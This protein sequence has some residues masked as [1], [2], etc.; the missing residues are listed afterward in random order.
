MAD[1]HDLEAERAVLG[2]LLH[3]P[4]L[5]E[6]SGVKGSDLDENRGHRAIFAA[7]LTVADRT[8]HPEVPM[9]ASELAQRDQL[10]SI[11]DS[12]GRGAPYL[13]DLFST[14]ALP[15]NLGYYAQRIRVASIRRGILEHAVRL[16]QVAE[17]ANDLDTVLDM[18]ADTMAQLSEI[19]DAPLEELEVPIHGLSRVDE[20]VHEPTAPYAWIIPGVLEHQDRVM[21]VAGEGIGKSVLARQIGLMVAAGRHPFAPKA[22]IPAKRTLL[23]DLENPPNLVRRKMKGQV[24]QMQAD[25]LATGDRAWR[26]SE[27]GGINVRSPQGRRMLER[28]I[29]QTRPDLILIGPLY[30]LSQGSGDKYEVEAAEVQQAIDSLRAKYG[31]AWWIEHHAP[32]GD[33]VE[34]SAMPYGSSYWMRWP[35]FGLT[36]KRAKDGEE[37]MFDLGRFRGDRDER[38]FPD[39]L[40]KLGDVGVP[41]ASDYEDPERLSEVYRLSEESMDSETVSF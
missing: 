35:E 32:K 38:Y 18:A 15:A 22:R 21:L 36:I 10:S 20:F 9:I 26:W 6:R 39:R 3:R 7:C 19:I 23:V 12:Q 4:D 5:A 24:L 33:A 34:R 11:G 14:A 30:K 29:E 40:L 28:V 13:A 31:C 25:G 41:W 2:C 37:N 17:G 8:A 16:Q 27:P 1:R